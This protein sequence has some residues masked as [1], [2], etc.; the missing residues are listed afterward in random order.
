VSKSSDKVEQTLEELIKNK[1]ALP[2]RARKD[3]VEHIRDYQ[4]LIMKMAHKY[5]RNRVEYDDLVQEAM[6]G[7]MM[8]DRDFD[9][10]RSEDFHTYAIY[11]MKGKMYEYCIGNESPIYVPTHVAKAASYVKQMRRLLE[12][13][14][15]LGQSEVDPDDVIRV[16]KHKIEANFLPTTRVDLKELKRKLGRI[17]INSKMEYEKLSDLAIKSLSLIVS[18][19][20]LMKVP[21]DAD[22][23]NDL[24]LTGEMKSYLK[25]HLGEKKYA[26]IEMRFEKWTYSDIA[27]KLYTMGYKN[28]EG[29][30]IS[31]QAVKGI[32]DDTLKTIRKSK[33]YKNIMQEENSEE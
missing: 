11:R 16:S 22:D 25:E 13:E 20:V 3:L 8:A 1:D 17:A 4:R 6:I 32:F 26:V 24:V 9:P 28:K 14:P 31:R 19:E 2:E 12:R 10:T 18:D 29:G 33:F 15:A 5:V 30:V 7:L 23:I 21:D 27:E